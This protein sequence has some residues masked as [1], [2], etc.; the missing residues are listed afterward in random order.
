ML[1]SLFSSFPVFVVTFYGGVS[2]GLQFCE[3]K[4]LENGFNTVK[5]KPEKLPHVLR[6]TKKIQ[7]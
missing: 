6:P 5:F 4:K 7:K 1:Q 2:D 3:F